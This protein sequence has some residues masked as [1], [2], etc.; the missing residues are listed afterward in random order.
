MSRTPKIHGH[1]G[2]RLAIRPRLSAAF[3]TAMAGLV[4]M[5]AADTARA[6][7]LSFE[8][9]AGIAK[10]DDAEAIGFSAGSF[11][12][13]P[14]PFQ[15][16]LLDRGLALG[17]S[18]LFQ[19]DPASNASWIGGGAFK[20]SNGSRGY[21]A[22]ANL[23]FSEGRWSARAVLVDADLNYDL[24]SQRRPLR[25]NQ[26]LRGASLEVGRAVSPALR[27][28]AALGYLETSFSRAGGG[29]LPPEFAADADIRLT[30]F[31]LGLDHDLRDGN[32]YPRQGSHVMARL[33]YGR[34]LNGR[35]RDYTKGVLT[36]RKYIPF[37]KQD[38]LAAQGV[39]CVASSSAP[40]LDACALGGVDA[41]RGYVAT[42]FIGDALASVQVEY[43]GRLKGRLGYVTFA[44]V[45]SVD[46][47]VSGLFGGDVRTAGGIGARFRLSRKFPVDYSVDMAINERG[48]RLLYVGVGQRF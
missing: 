11:I 36:A 14:I 15:S 10:P 21:A 39:F 5:M 43:R 25:V 2:S 29:Q 32:F 30:R 41:F 20:T 19:F 40:F 28:S 18:Y 37:G 44:G 8:D 45:G 23:N 12:L 22:G 6:Q 3:A 24:Y 31:S 33:T 47:D 1:S 9:P 7:D 4:L 17:G 38:V 26:T 46:D 35:E 34:F 42:E 27:L 48:D 13:A 16:P